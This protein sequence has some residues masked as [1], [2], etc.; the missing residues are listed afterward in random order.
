MFIQIERALVTQIFIGKNK[1]DYVTLQLEGGGDFKMA[2]PKELM[3]DL[4]WGAMVGFEAN[5][6]T[7]LFNNNLNIQVINIKIKTL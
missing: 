4:V 7:R 5:C 2:V 3:K 6:K 1:S